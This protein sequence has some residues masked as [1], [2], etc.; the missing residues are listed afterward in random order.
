MKK[1]KSGH[2]LGW[3]AAALIGTMAGCIN[4]TIPGR[5]SGKIE[6]NSCEGCHTDYERLMAVHSPDTAPPAGGYEGEV[7]FYEPYDRVFMG[8]EGYNA[9][10]AS[11][12]SSVGCTGCHNGIGDT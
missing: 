3:I 8:G 1:L 5:D 4:Y 9:F 2:N 11:G 12:H 7:P 6:V 10:K